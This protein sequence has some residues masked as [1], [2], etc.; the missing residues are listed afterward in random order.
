MKIK[1]AF[2][3]TACLLLTAGIF[4][5]TP[6]VT[7]TEV[8]AAE[9]MTET[10]NNY[11]YAAK[12]YYPGWNRDSWF[13]VKDGAYQYY[14]YESTDHTAAWIYRIDMLKDSKMLKIPKMLEGKKVTRLGQLKR[15][16]MNIFGAW[17]DIENTY[18]QPRGYRFEKIEKLSIPETVTLIQNATFASMNHLKSV[19]IP[20]NVTELKQ[21]VFA[22]CTGLKKVVLPDEL[23]K[24]DYRAFYNCPKL[25]KMVLN[26]NNAVFKVENRCIITKKDHRLI[27]VGGGTKKLDVPEGT[28]KIEDFAFANCNASE[29]YIP[30]SVNKISGWAFVKGTAQGLQGANEKI[31]DITVSAENPVFARDGQCIYNKKD[32]SLVAGIVD[33]NRCL[34]ISEKVEKIDGYDFTT[35]HCNTEHRALK[36]LYLPRNLKC[37]QLGADRSLEAEKVYYTGERPPKLGANSRPLGCFYRGFT[38]YIPKNSEKLYKTWFKKKAPNFGKYGKIKTYYP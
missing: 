3:K 13:T 11:S 35:V 37:L 10:E 12:S 30:A 29:V 21:E 25:T 7:L 9:V 27:Y 31:S 15:M 4:F 32:K 2:I 24:F 14:A 6:G 36:R 26:K 22:D 1:T 19:V 17:Q 38:V 20:K 34:R 28:K 5:G 16:A 23:K 33:D 18:G 8:S